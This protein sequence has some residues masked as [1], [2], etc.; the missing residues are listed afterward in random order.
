MVFLRQILIQALR[1]LLKEENDRI[2]YLKELF[3][4]TDEDRAEKV[5]SDFCQIKND[6]EKSK[7]SERIANCVQSNLTKS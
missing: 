5:F 1:V 7:C 4:V 2:S 6:N 3:D